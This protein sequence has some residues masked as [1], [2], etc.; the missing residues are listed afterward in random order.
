MHI[1]ISLEDGVPIYLQIMNQVKYLVAVGQ[2]VA[3]DE[4]PAIRTLAEQLLVTPNTVVRAYRE[5]ELAG[6]VEKRRTAGTFVTAAGSPLN[7]QE[8]RRILSQR[9]DMLI[10]EARQLDVCLDEVI[11]LVRERDGALQAGADFEV[12]IHS[13]YREDMP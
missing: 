12:A 9:A 6:V 7:R 10:V 2:L 13:T 3:G 11:E 5:L 4:M 8:R 1:Q